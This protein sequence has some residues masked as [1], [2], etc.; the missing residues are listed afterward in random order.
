[1]G[2]L[3]GSQAAAAPL[4]VVDW[5]GWKDESW[6]VA[7]VQPQWVEDPTAIAALRQHLSALESL[8]MPAR[9]QGLWVQTGS[10]I[11]GEHQG[12]EPIP[13]ASLTKIPTTLAALKTWGTAHTF[14]TTVGITGSVQNGVVQGDLVVQGGGDPLFVWEEA[15]A[16]GNALE[17]RGIRRVTGNL[18]ITGDF[19]M[20]FNA[21]PQTAGALLKQGINADLWTGEAQTQYAK[22]PAGTPQPRLVIDGSVISLA[23]SPAFTPVLQHRSLNLAQ[24]LKAMNIFSNN[25]IADSVARQLGGGSAVAQTAAAAANVPAAEIRL[26]NGSGLGEENQISP[27][28]VVAMLTATQRSLRTESLSV[29]DLF[30]VVGRERGTLGDR[31]IPPGTPVK[32]GTLD[33][34]SSLAGALPTRDRGVVWFAIIDIGTADLSSVRAEQDRLL[35]AL[36]GHWGEAAPVPPELQPSDRLPIYQQQLGDPARNLPL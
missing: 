30:P 20:N 18:V 36:V 26:I 28:A 13:A 5:A 12:L 11:L 25:F 19:A 22:L 6:L 35:Q 29:S 34:V 14:N 3:P 23:Q 4:Q 2:L 32:T 9:A 17:Q 8:G 31:R 16:L 21:D 24:V 7:L 1:M 15:I 10:Q 33:R 27:R